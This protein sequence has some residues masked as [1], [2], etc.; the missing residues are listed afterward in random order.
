MTTR[1][2]MSSVA[3]LPPR[4]QRS[5]ESFERVL[6]AGGAL[7]QDEGYESFTLAAVSQ[8]AD[9]SIGSIYARVKSKDDLFYA[10]QDR[11][12]SEWVSMPGF[13]TD[14]DAYRGL[15]TGDLVVEAIRDVDRQ[16]RQNERL[17]RVFMHRGIVDRAVADRS[18]ASVALR[19]DAFATLLLAHRDEIVRPDPECA[20]DIAFRMAWGTLARQILY[21]PTFESEHAI[22]WDTLVDE[23]AV[24]CS[25]YLIGVADV[26]LGQRPARAAGSSI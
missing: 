13:V 8:H 24:A 11:F 20:V 21:G 15:P 9:V 26:R 2:D 6:L 18:S 25:A 17:L 12:M 1:R 23:L 3:L 19:A 14:T 22:G 7:L 10:I 16:F 5:R 4:Q